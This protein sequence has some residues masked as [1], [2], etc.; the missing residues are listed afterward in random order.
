LLLGGRPGITVGR[1]RGLVI[2]AVLAPI[3]VGCASAFLVVPLV[4]IARGPG[5]LAAGGFG[6]LH[7]FLSTWWLPGL[8]AIPIGALV[9]L[10]HSGARKP[11]RRDPDESPRDRLRD[12]PIDGASAPREGTKTPAGKPV[13]YI[14]IG[15][16]VAATFLWALIAT[17]RSDGRPGETINLDVAV[18]V[19]LIATAIA[20]CVG[21]LVG[22][23]R[24][25][26]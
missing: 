20:A 2:G 16:G 10:S 22:R 17:L 24:R 15:F 7:R 26:A 23:L 1:V 12:L 8:S 19:G 4:D 14:A 13:G 3:V 9:G 18:F 11:D 25:R 21:S 6:G 5:G